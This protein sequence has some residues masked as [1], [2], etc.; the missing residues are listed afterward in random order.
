MG[1]SHAASDRQP[2]VSTYETDRLVVAALVLSACGS[3][4][5]HPASTTTSGSSGP[6]ATNT[7]SPTAAATLDCSKP[8]N[9]AQQLVCS[10]P[11]LTDLDQR[12]QMA[13][14]NSST[15]GRAS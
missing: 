10:D 14:P 8:A 11:Q 3:Q 2:V 6:P 4:T 7:T 13:A 5:P 1:V 9:T 12:V 15:Y